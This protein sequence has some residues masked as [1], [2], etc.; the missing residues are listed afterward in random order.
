M[1]QDAE[2][3]AGRRVLVVE[4]DAVMRGSLAQ[5]LEAAGWTALVLSDPTVALKETAAFEPDVLVFDVRMPKM[6]GLELL[7]SLPIDSPPVVLISAHGDVPTAVEAMSAGAYSFI[8]KPFDPRRFLVVLRNAADKH[9][10]SLNAARLRERL[11]SLSQIDKIMLGATPRMQKLREALIDLAPLPTNVMILGETGVGKELVARALH[12]LSQRADQ[13]F[14]ALNCAAIPVDAF[15][16]HMFEGPGGE[17]GAMLR[18]DGGSLFLDEVG[19]CPAEAQA[20]F[21]RAIETREFVAASGRVRQVDIRVISASNA[22]LDQATT[23]NAIRED[24][25][26]RLGAVILDVPPLRE[27]RE[28]IPLLFHHF[29]AHYARLYEID[30]PELAAEDIAAMMAHD[31]PGNVRELRNVAERRVLSAKRGGGSVS[32]SIGRDGDVGDAPETLREAVAAFE[33]QLIGR[34]IRSHGGRMDAVAEALGIG[35]RTLNEKIVK[36]GLDK[37]ELL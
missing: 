18:A 12:D 31:W 28:D 11:A 9:R 24:L 37:T 3:D 5:L 1:K 16:A 17:P 21:L 13:P 27:R 34:A 35:R 15:D 29:A 14:V 23:T 20:K 19:A 2:S 7:R 25:F 26:Y 4:D 36:L 32:T 8:E 6:S 30:E 10:L 33:R 22:P